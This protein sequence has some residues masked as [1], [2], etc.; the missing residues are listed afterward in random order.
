MEGTKIKLV[1]EE[2]IPY[3]E[4]KKLVEVIENLGFNCTSVTESD[5]NILFDKR[6]KRG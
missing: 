3:G 1:V 4:L 6:H 5:G 2:Y